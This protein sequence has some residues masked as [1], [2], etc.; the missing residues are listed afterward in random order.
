MLNKSNKIYIFA[1]TFYILLSMPNNITD[2][3]VS[4]IEQSASIDIAEAEFKRQ[5]ADDSI[6]RR[7]YKE[8]CREN[9]TT[10]KHGFLDFCNEYVDGQNEVWDALTDYDE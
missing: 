9:G 2:F 4:I 8:W 6:L 3:F 7:E 1:Y 5:I 10:E